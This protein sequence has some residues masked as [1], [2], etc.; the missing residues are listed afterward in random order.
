MGVRGYPRRDLARGE[1]S[2]SSLGVGGNNVR[3]P[4]PLVRCESNML[5]RCRVPTEAMVMT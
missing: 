3:I 5:V 2:G 4:I 1:R